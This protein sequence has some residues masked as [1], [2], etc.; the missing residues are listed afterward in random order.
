MGLGY[1]GAT[2]AHIARRE[3]KIGCSGNGAHIGAVH[4]LD[5]TSKEQTL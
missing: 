1:L 2:S 5:F 4:K 3:P